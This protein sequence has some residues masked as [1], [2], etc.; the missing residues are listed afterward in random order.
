MIDEFRKFIG[1]GNVIDLAVGVIVGGMFG[2]IVTAFVDD[3][4]NP[5]LGLMGKADFTNLYIPLSDKVTPGLALADARKLGP[6]LA[7]G[8]FVTTVINV[9]LTTFAIFLVVKGINRM[10]EMGTKPAPETAPAAPPPPP[11]DVVLLT[12]IRDLLRA[13]RP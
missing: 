5:V 1:S 2:K 9:L 10:R 11:A 6:V 8:D 7:W 3:L 4:V 12:E 13:P